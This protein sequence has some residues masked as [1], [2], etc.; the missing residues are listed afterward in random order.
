[1]WE[2]N[3]RLIDSLNLNIFCERKN[4]ILINTKFVQFCRPQAKFCDEN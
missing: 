1:M 2:T 4:A 3:K